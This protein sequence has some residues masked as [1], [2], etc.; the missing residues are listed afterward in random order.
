[1][2]YLFFK[3]L[4]Q[5]PTITSAT[6]HLGVNTKTICMIFKTGKSYDNFIYKFKVKD[7]RIW[8]YDNN[9]KL[10]ITS[11]SLKKV[12]KWSKIPTYTIS[13]YIKLG[14]LYKNK[15]YFY[16]INYKSNPYFNNK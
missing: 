15:Y 6:R 7:N 5:F 3:T 12:S 4:N 2:I 11:Y 16:N 14:K 10:I 13:D 1:M 9:Y 8:I